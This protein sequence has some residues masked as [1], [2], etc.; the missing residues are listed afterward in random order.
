MKLCV[1]PNDP[2]ESYLK[3]GEIKPRYF[4]PENLFEEIHVLSLF[5]SDTVPEN[6]KE[7][8]G[9]AKLEIHIIGKTNLLNVKL[10]EKKVI[11]LIKK[12][13]PDVIRS[14]NPLLQGWLATKIGKK[15]KIPVIISLMGDYDRDLRYH[16]RKNGK[17]INYLKLKYTRNTLEMFSIK[18]ADGIIIIYEFIRKYAESLGGKN[19]N[20]I[21]NKIDLSKF[22][23]KIIPKIIEK[24]PIIIC[25]GRLM[26]EK[27]QE[28]LI[29]AIK[30]LDVILLLVGDGPQYSELVNL[31]EK[32][33]L[34]Q[35]V[36]FER[37]IPNNEINAYYTSADIFALPIKYGGFAIPALEAAASGIPVILP[38][39]KFDSNPEIIEK[40][41]MLVDNTSD[42]FQKAIKEILSNESLKNKMIKNGVETVKSISGDLMEKKENELYLKIISKN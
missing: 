30:D 42:S 10:K 21:Y 3:K 4:N 15:L 6:V 36:R 39:Q 14:F 12:I 7:L 1:F 35:K 19:I 8:A 28:C 22:S 11:E 33:D 40:F 37:S 25:V 5:D 2:L 24:K 9:N 32:L 34:K 26:K 41:A 27:N 13:N 20:L 17:W 29:H 31:V 18:N 38:K 23:P 16:A